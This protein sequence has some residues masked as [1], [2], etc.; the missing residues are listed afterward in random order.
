MKW[1]LVSIVR[2]CVDRNQNWI[3]FY[4]NNMRDLSAS[5]LSFD[6][7]RALTIALAEARFGRELWSRN[8]ERAARALNSVMD[9]AFE[10][11]QNTGAWLSLWLGFALEMGGDISSAHHYYRQAHSVASNIPGLPSVTRTPRNSI[12]LQIVRVSGQMQ[13]GHANSISIE[14]PKT[15][16]NSLTA[17]KGSMSPNQTEE[18]LRYLGQYL[19]LDSTRPDKEFGAGPDVLWIGDQGVALCM[20]VKTDKQPDSNYRKEE[21]GQLHNHIQWVKNNRQSTQIIPIFVGPVL[22]ATSSA[23]PTSE[24]RMVELGQFE[25]L[26]QRLA[27]VMEDVAANTLPL[28]LETDLHD[29][30]RDR[31]LLYPDLLGLLDTHSFF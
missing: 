2:T 7:D 25:D 29:T 14:I 24:M 28:S 4:N 23:S 31:G 5:T 15:M 11:S 30:M 13:V 18:A 17:L 20:E 12:P 8:Y 9:D 3:Q 21:T 22:P 10:F 1:L 16:S 27:V 6:F 26:A 19:G